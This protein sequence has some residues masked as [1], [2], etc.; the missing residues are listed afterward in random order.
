MLQGGDTEDG[1][2]TV[3]PRVFI[4]SP[5][6]V[7]SHLSPDDARRQRI[8]NY[9]LACRA[10]QDS[11][12]RGEAP[13]LLH[14]HYP[15]VTSAYGAHRS[16][17]KDAM[18]AWL[19]QADVLVLVTAKGEEATSGMK[20]QETYA[21]END[22][23]VVHRVLHDLDLDAD[24]ASFQSITQHLAQIEF[25]TITL[26]EGQDC[27]DQSS[28]MGNALR[29]MYSSTSSLEDDDDVTENNN[30]DV[31]ENDDVTE[32]A[33]LKVNSVPLPLLHPVTHTSRHTQTETDVYTV[34]CTEKSLDAD[35]GSLVSDCVP[36]IPTRTVYR[37][38]NMDGVASDCLSC[39][40]DWTVCKMQTHEDL[41]AIRQGIAMAFGNMLYRWRFTMDESVY[42]PST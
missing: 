7:S 40:S 25:L 5:W 33:H 18:E 20:A 36:C 28:S 6:R 29:N 41:C 27:V 24:E 38:N 22:I 39:V 31:A 10:M 21:T 11:L 12:V 32:R 30:D 16:V 34:L 8:R 23:R 1:P 3:L 35:A 37:T 42:T 17:G 4:S 26:Q 19:S 13:I 15:L 14:L 2:D 9:I